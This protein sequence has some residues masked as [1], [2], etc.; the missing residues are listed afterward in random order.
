MFK[1]KLSNNTSNSSIYASVL[2]PKRRNNIDNF[3]V[4]AM[5]M[6]KYGYFC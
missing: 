6:T 2:I 4:I 5:E 3:P 1:N